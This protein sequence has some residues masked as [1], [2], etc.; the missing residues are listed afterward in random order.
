M[1]KASGPEV[2]VMKQATHRMLTFLALS[3]LVCGM[4]SAAALLQGKQLTGALAGG[5]YVIL[6]RHASSPGTPPAPDQTEP[7]NVSH[8]PQLD[9]RGRASARAMGEALRRLK[10]PVGKV[11]SSTSY[12]ALETAQLAQ[13]P[14]PHTYDELTEAGRSAEASGS[15]RA[16][17]AVAPDAGTNTFI[18]THY[19]NITDAFAA[20]AKDR[21]EG[22]AL[23]YHPDG[24]GKA[25][26]VARVKIEDWPKLAAAP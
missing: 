18:I 8:E 3:A 4:A 21:A 24:H 22:E 23:V 2:N 17:V 12:R 19:P 16:Q 25:A 26:L 1:G 14:D 20:D 7:A 13:F 10:I 5:G 9:E 15:L 11:L 6:M